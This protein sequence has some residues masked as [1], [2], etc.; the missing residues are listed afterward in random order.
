MEIADKAFYDGRYL[1]KRR[2]DKGGLSIIIPN[3]V[4][5]D[6]CDRPL[7][8]EM[9]PIVRFLKAGLSPED[10]RTATVYWTIMNKI[11]H[12]SKQNEQELQIL[13]SKEGKT[14]KKVLSEAL[15]FYR[16]KGLCTK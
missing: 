13:L 11:R 15:K 12:R 3:V 9:T 16:A 14:G 2:N 7:L 5:R 6:G 1:L 10:A 4:E 8:V